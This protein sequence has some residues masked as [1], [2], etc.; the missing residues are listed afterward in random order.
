MS[1]KGR[2]DGSGPS[3]TRVEDGPADEDRTADD[4]ATDAVGRVRQ[5]VDYAVLGG[6]LLLAFI[7][8]VQFYFAV[9]SV[10][11]TWVT[12]EYRP[13]FRAAFNL[14][15]LLVAG[16]GISRQLL[17]IGRSSGES[18]GDASPGHGDD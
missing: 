16:V 1:E 9:G 12:P 13:L 3:P 10:I 17:R 18:D 6:L 4:D 8:V 15:V 2:P 14:V 5:V 7:A 11:N